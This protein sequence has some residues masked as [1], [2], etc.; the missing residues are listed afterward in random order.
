[1]NCNLIGIINQQEFRIMKL[2]YLLI[3][4]FLAVFTSCSYKQKITAENIKLLPYYQSG[5]ILQTDSNTII[6]GSADPESILAVKIMEYVRLVEVDAQGKWEAVFPKIILK[7]SVTILIEGRDTI[8]TIPNVKAGKLIIVFGDAQLDPFKSNKHCSCSYTDSLSKTS[9]SIYNP[10]VKNSAKGNFNTS[11]KWMPLEDLPM[12]IKTCNTLK[13]IYKT[14]GKSRIPLVGI[15]DATWP[16]ARM[17]AWL[18]SESL[19]ILP[20]SNHLEFAGQEKNIIFN[21]SLNDSIKHLN[22][23]GYKGIKAGVARIWFNDDNWRITDMPIDFT[24]KNIPSNKKIIYLRKKIYIP[25]RYFTS[26]FIFNLGYINGDAEFY[27]NQQK[28]KPKVTNGYYSINIADTLLHEWSNLICIRLFCAYD[29]SGIYGSLF[30][31]YN[32][33]ST[34]Y[35]N[36][37]QEWKYNYNL[38]ADFPD[39]VI[40]TAKPGILHNNL[41]LEL[42]ELPISELIWYGGYFDVD[43]P[44]GISAKTEE[45]LGY[46]PRLSTRTILF[47]P[48]TPIDSIL[49]GNNTGIVR[50]ELRRAAENSNARWIEIQDGK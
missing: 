25:S 22:Q 43:N 24:L 29:H 46:F 36:I 28:V 37:D 5:M 40:N 12:D 3:I 13:S 41:L 23:S 20:D 32:N 30:D 10:E 8:I 14:I 1:M 48:F 42:K 21:N 11:G 18:N 9:I 39:F 45:I 44:E 34:F 4:L 19:L 2:I 33:D 31:C 17:V 38:E 26:D 16:G 50:N 7:K 35:R 49:Y 15:I 47:T 6:Q 27:F